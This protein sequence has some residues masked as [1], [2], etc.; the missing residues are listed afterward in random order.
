VEPKSAKNDINVT[1]IH[2]WLALVLSFLCVIL[3]VSVIKRFLSLSKGWIV[4]YV[5]YTYDYNFMS[6]ELFSIRYMVLGYMGWV[7]NCN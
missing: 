6:I 2:R 3:V 4:L 5:T 1:D 7:S